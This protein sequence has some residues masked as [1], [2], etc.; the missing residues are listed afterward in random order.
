MRDHEPIDLSNTKGL[1]DR[2]RDESTPVGH[3]TI[4]QNLEFGERETRSRKGFSLDTTIAGVVRMWEYAPPNQTRRKLILDNTGKIWDSL[5]LGT[6]PVSGWILS[7]PAMTDFSAVTMFGRAYI[8][9]HNGV[10]GLPGQFVYVYSGGG[11]AARATGGIAPV[12]FAT[13]ATGGAGKVDAGVHLVA[14]AYETDTGYITKP[15]TRYKYT[16]ATAG[17]QIN[18]TT[19]PIGPAGTVARHILVTKAIVPSLYTGNV[20]DYELFY[21][22]TAKISNN[23]ATTKTIDFYDSDLSNSADY[24]IDNLDS[25]PAGNCILN[26]SGTLLVG[27]EDANGSI[28]RASQSGLPENMSALD[29]FLIIN[30]GDAGGDVKNI[31]ENAGNVYIAKSA[32]TYF[33]KNNGLAAVYWDVLPMDQAIGTDVHGFSKVVDTQGNTLDVF[34]MADRSGLIRYT[35]SFVDRPLTY[36][37]E[38]IWNRVNEAAWNKIQVYMDPKKKRIYVSVPLDSAVDCSHILVGDYQIGMDYNNIRWDMWVL[39]QVIKCI[40]MEIHNTTL[41]PELK[42]GNNNIYKLDDT[43]ISDYGTAIDSFFDTAY[44]PENISGEIY[45]Y[46]MVTAR[47]TGNGALQLIL[48]SIDDTIIVTAPSLNLSSGPGRYLQRLVNLSVPRL[49]LRCRVNLAGEYFSITNL[50]VHCAGLWKGQLQ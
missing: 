49:K 27:G 5:Y 13:A 18:L 28:V 29:G 37:I 50:A 31:V 10:K 47:A 11:T 30:P 3:F 48:S 2:G 26:L 45:H 4:S 39:P 24:L 23:T 17:K 43:V 19:I 21:L 46:H 8:S 44:I 34:L 20:D 7:I 6:Y 25:I 22:D 42:F 35:G 40:A 9:P 14:I 32:R 41:K 33:T 1:Y 38:A 16:A 36:K 15:S 12:G